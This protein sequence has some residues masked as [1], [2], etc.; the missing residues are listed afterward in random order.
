MGFNR[1]SL[2]TIDG[3]LLNIP[4]IV[5]AKRETDKSI[6]YD[7]NKTRLDR[8][9]GAIYG[10]DTYGWLI[11]FANPQYYNEFEIPKNAVIRVPYPLQDAK[12]DFERQIAEKK[13]K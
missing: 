3:K 4:K 13:N 9:S 10:D 2:V 7:A 11:L 5:I 8:I 12:G 6:T 1:Y